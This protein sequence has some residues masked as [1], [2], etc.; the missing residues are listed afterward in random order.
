MERQPIISFEHVPHE[1]EAEAHIL[2]RIDRLER[3]FDRIVGCRAVVTL[4]HKRHETGNV[5][6]VHVH[7]DVPGH[8]IFVGREP[9]VDESHSDLRI[10]V[11]A[12]FDTAERRPGSMSA[13]CATTSSKGPGRR[14]GVSSS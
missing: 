14:T 12:A 8:D 9:E 2:D 7:I 4:P 6:E 13:G 5:Y 1:P 3:I 10:A 11:G